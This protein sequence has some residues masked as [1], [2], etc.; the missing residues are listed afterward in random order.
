[1]DEIRRQFV[2][3]KKQEKHDQPAEDESGDR[4]RNHWHDYFRP[5]S[6]VPFDHRP[7]TFRSGDGRAAKSADERMARAR[8]QPKQPGHHVPNERSENSAKHSSHR[9]NASIDQ[10]FTDSCRDRAA[11]KCAS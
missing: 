8:R 5:K 3:H 9:D 11:E 7:I 2:K 1:M 6:F 4:R 10:A